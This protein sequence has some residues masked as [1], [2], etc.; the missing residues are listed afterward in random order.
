MR[1]IILKTAAGPDYTLNAGEARE[2]LP[3]DLARALIAAGAALE[4]PAAMLSP[5]DLANL[6]DH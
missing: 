6:G 3:D 2:D 4:D 5:A 1:V